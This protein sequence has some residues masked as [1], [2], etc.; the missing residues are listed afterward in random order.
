MIV[1]KVSGDEKYAQF[2]DIID[3]RR[4]AVGFKP[5]PFDYENT[6]VRFYRWLPTG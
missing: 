4:I 2:V 6:Q 5:L 1:A 3:H